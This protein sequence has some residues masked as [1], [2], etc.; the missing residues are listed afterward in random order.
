M[1]DDIVATVLLGAA[2]NIGVVEPVLRASLA[3]GRPETRVRSRSSVGRRERHVHAFLGLC[4][5]HGIANCARRGSAGYFAARMEFTEDLLVPRARIV[6][7][8]L[9]TRC[10]L[11]CVYCAVSKPDYVGQDHELDPRALVRSIAALRPHEVQISGHGESTLVKGWV[12]LAR[13]LLDQ[14]CPVTMISNLA[15]RLSDEE[16]DVMSQFAG[17][18]VSCDSANP[19]T[20]ATLR[21]GGKLEKL[22]G[23]LR[24]I[25]EAADASGRHRP[26]V[27][28][29]CVLTELNLPDLEKLVDWAKANGAGGVSLTNLQ[30]YDELADIVPNHPS[31]VAGAHAAV[32]RARRR[33]RELGL[34]FNAMGGLTD[35]LREASA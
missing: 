21:R 19:E 10:N 24:R 22:E 14:G 7:L 33:A 13:D 25:L 16:V 31:T 15:K 3:R 34:E 9:T 12:E 1:H 29:N 35:A 6:M 30:T 2:G 5:L 26:Y 27:G 17:L 4:A 11:R 32:E 20:F 28:I 18:T 8:E 23:N